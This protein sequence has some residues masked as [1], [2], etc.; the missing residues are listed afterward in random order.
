MSS[1]VDSGSPAPPSAAALASTS[2]SSPLAVAAS[3][4]TSSPPLSSIPS[5]SPLSPTSSSSSSIIAAESASVIQLRELLNAAIDAGDVEGAS[6]HAASLARMKSALRAAG[7]PI[8][9]S[10][11]RS[12][13]S[14]AVNAFAA[15][16]SPS[17]TATGTLSDR[18]NVVGCKSKRTKE[19][20][21]DEHYLLFKPV[22]DPKKKKQREKEEK[23]KEK[24]RVKKE[25]EAKKLREKT[26]KERRKNSGGYDIPLSTTPV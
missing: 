12:P 14:G 11:P 25:K 5:Q 1:T 21:C 10:T 2:I 8:P 24:E 16:G 23:A 22:E 4:S 3:S 17:G 7:A 26:L 9:S 13:A 18:C 15:G 20:Y 19:T 6:R